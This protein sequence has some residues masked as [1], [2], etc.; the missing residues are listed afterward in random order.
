MKS[1]VI[2]LI[3]ALVAIGLTIA[4]YN[5]AVSEWTGMLQ[6]SLAVVCI[7][8]LAVICTM[9]L[10]P[11]MNFKNGSTGILINVYAA[12]MIIWSLIGCSFDG[13]TY[14]IGLL[15]ISVAML[16]VIGFSVMGSHES[17]RLNDKVEQTLT[18]K[19]SFTSAAPTTT[20][21]AM[22]AAENL[23]SMWLTM[24]S[25]IDDYDTKKR[26]RI[27]VERIKALPANRFPNSTIEN[28]MRELSAMSRGLANKDA[29]DRILSRMNIKITELTN[30][31]KS[32]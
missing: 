10:L 23:S 31:I 27:L 30:Y 20:T 16:A 18:R 22:P 26:V 13:N 24:Q 29:H 8:E 4:L 19:T 32:I 11:A 12:L 1:K 25:A 5:L 9:G 3:T 6:L 7:S 15:L 28:G 2:L 14:P 21:A 17:D